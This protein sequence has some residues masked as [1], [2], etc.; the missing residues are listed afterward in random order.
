MKENVTNINDFKKGAPTMIKLTYKTLNSQS[1]NQALEY[2]TA[3]QGFANFNA[4]Y[5]VAK[6]SRKIQEELKI[7]REL[8]TKATDVLLEKDEKGQPVMAKT[9]NPWTPFQILEGKTEE[10]GKLFEEFLAK[11]IQIE[12]RY[13]QTQDVGN[14]K[15]SP[16]Q[17]L[18]LEPIFDPS[19]F[20]SAPTP[21]APQTV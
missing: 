6:I 10:Y 21:A 11:E 4:A 16:Q 13:I 1:F 12:G 19:T 9:P 3:Q 7:A 5:N 2:L 14:V 15:L 17:M 18:T 20:G 8:Y